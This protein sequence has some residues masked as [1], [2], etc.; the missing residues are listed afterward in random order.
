MKRLIERML[1]R[2][3]GRITSYPVTD[4]YGGSDY[5][6]TMIFRG[7]RGCRNINMTDIRLDE[8]GRLKAGGID[9][10]DGTVEKN[11][12]ILPEHYARTLAFLAFAL[13]IRQSG[14]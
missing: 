9:D 10:H 11:L 3:G 4:E 8:N 1:T 7:N 2:H 6:V 14:L 13:G 12:E 5:P